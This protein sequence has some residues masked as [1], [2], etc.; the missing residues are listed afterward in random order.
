MQVRG[1]KKRFGG[2]TVDPYNH[3]KRKLRK[4]EMMKFQKTDLMSKERTLR[5][6]ELGLPLNYTSL[7]GCGTN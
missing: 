6:M 5:K 1:A 7:S 2:I 4:A 3:L